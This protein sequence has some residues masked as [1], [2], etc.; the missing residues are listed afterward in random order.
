KGVL[1]LIAFIV[2]DLFRFL[3]HYLMHRLPLLKSLHRTHHS[4]LVLTPLTLFRSHPIESFIA[5]MR[6]VLSL[7]ITLA[8]FSFLN[9][10]PIQGWDILGVN[11]FGFLFNALFANL[12]HSPVPISFGLLECVFISP[13]MHQVHHSNN[14]KHWDKNYGVALALWDQIAGSYYRPSSSE[15]KDLK[16][17]LH[18]NPSKDSKE[19]KEATTLSG[20]LFPKVGKMKAPKGSYLFLW[21]R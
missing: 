18:Q 20:A 2:N 6:N 7:G 17:G 1:T 16:F 8:L 12:R 11:L 21:N 19:W 3:H 15:A 13:R 10:K 9:Q 14:P 4:A 5:S